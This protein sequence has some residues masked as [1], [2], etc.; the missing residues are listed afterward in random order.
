M[1][2]PG[3]AAVAPSRGCLVPLKWRTVFGIRPCGQMVPIPSLV[4][5][6]GA[7][8]VVVIGVCPL[9]EQGC[10]SASA[11]TAMIALSVKRKLS[12]A[13]Y[14]PAPCPR[15]MSETASAGRQAAVVQPAA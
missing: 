8:C 13:R 5:I 11:A 7:G 9:G 15:P 3:A 2:E 10:G 14:G 1:P 12:C 4:R 6:T